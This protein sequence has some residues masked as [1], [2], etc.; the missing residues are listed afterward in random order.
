MVSAYGR[1]AQSQREPK[2]GSPSHRKAT[3]AA[4]LNTQ[5]I[6]LMP[7]GETW[8]R[9]SPAGGS[10]EDFCLVPHTAASHEVFKRN[11]KGAGWALEQML[12]ATISSR[13]KRLAEA[14][15]PTAGP[16]ERFTIGNGFESQVV[17]YRVTSSHM[18]NINRHPDREAFNNGRGSSF[19]SGNLQRHCSEPFPLQSKETEGRDSFSLLRLSPT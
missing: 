12:M 5:S 13:G 1:M 17:Y 10:W 15:L 4:Q 16:G 11:L 8:V 6:L 2:I 19:R 18:K 3:V 14:H 7:R 9:T